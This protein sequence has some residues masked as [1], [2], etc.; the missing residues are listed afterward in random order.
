MLKGSLG[1][2]GGWGAGRPPT[3][4]IVEKAWPAWVTYSS[5]AGQAEGR[6]GSGGRGCIGGQRAGQ[7]S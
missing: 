4:A 7:L 1:T 2:T 3:S 6:A 5:P